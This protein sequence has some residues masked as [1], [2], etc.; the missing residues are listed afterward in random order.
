MTLLSLAG[1]NLFTE[2]KFLSNHGVEDILIMK[3]HLGLSP[4]HVT[5]PGQRR[6]EPCSVVRGC[7]TLLNRAL[8][9]ILSP[10]TMIPNNLALLSLIRGWFYHP[11]Q[12]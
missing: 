9:D 10:L 1:F 12:A 4:S 5:F 8:G 11:H 6:C 3:E 2:S 7:N